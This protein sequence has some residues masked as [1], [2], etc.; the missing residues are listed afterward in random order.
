MHG[1]DI[2]EMAHKNAGLKLIIAIGRLLSRSTATKGRGP[3]IGSLETNKP[4]SLTRSSVH[5]NA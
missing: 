1:V 5:S 3:G 2:C 4:D